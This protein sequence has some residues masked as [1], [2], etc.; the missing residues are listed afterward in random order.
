VATNRVHEQGTNLDWEVA[1]G[2]E[3]GEPILIGGTGV[4][5][6]PGVALTDRG[7][8]DRATVQ[9]GGV[10]N[11][12]VEGINAGGNVAIAEGDPVFY[13]GADD[14]VLN[15]KVGGTLFGWAREAVASG[16]TATIAVKLV[17]R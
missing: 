14:P 6:L 4:N 3:S 17:T 9:H 8:D 16:A 12:S 11:L 1:S 13:T 7:S 10:F 5:A 2:V 15:A